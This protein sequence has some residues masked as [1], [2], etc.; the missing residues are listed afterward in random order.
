MIMDEPG[1]HKTQA[2]IA[3]AFVQVLFGV[4]YVISKVIVGAFPPLIWAA[5]RVI[6]AAL[7]LYGISVG[8]KRP[9]PKLDLDFFLHIIPYSFLG[10]IINQASFLVGLHYTTPTNSSILN[11]LIPVF[12]LI[13]VTLAG[14]ERLSLKR[15]VGFVLALSGVLALRN[16]ED[17]SISNQ[18]LLGDSLTILN[19]L[20]YAIFLT[21]SKKFISTHDT[22]WVTTWMFAFGSVGLT[23]LSLPYWHD[24]Q[25][26]GLTGEMIAC[27]VF[28]ILG[29]TLLAY[30]LN[31]WALVRLK[32]S[33]VALF[34]Y[35]QPVV[36]SILAWIWFG[37]L[38]TVRTVLS[39]GLI[40]SGMVLSLKNSPRQ[41]ERP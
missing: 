38:P 36:A 25:M 11:T 4:N 21:V 16:V 26:P 6:V 40:F 19:C 27:M 18:T 1:S 15:I 8:L 30:L 17:F 10:V 14:Q 5:F 29:S 13:L 12:T 34:I 33:S 23:V 7:A 24:F 37:D 35:V 3:V 32:S 39:S 9:R 20:S 41:T 31:N 2:L 22:L 28:S